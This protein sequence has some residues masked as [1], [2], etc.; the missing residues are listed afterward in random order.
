MRWRGFLPDDF[1]QSEQQ[2]QKSLKAQGP[3]ERQG[4]STP[5]ASTSS[6][7]VHRDKRC[8]ISSSA[9]CGVPIPGRFPRQTTMHDKDTTEQDSAESNASRSVSNKRMVRVVFTTGGEGS[10]QKPQ[11]VN[12]KIESGEPGEPQS[13]IFSYEGQKRV[14]GKR[15][16]SNKRCC[17]LGFT[18]FT[19]PVESL[20]RLAFSLVNPTPGVVSTTFTN[21]KEV[22]Q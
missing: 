18:T 11:D 13:T 2:T 21:T 6:S 22:T 17:R 8:S 7:V 16:V 1:Q 3:G 9:Y 12:T 10:P 15:L 14:G 4:L 20:S 5:L 19:T